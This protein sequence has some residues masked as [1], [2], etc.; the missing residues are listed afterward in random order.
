MTEEEFKIIEK[1]YWAA[2]DKYEAAKKEILKERNKRSL[3]FGDNAR[4]LNGGLGRYIGQGQALYA[5][6]V[7]KSGVWTTRLTRDLVDMDAD[8]SN[9]GNQVLFPSDEELIAFI[10][11]HNWI[12]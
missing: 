12:E 1:D 3:K 10:K 2:Q 11:E 6:R 9:Y 7:E 4:C 8:W 5:D